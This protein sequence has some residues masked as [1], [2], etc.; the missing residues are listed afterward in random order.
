[1][2]VLRVFRKRQ[3][4]FFWKKC[5]FFGKKGCKIASAA[6]E[7]PIASGGWGSAPK[8][9]RYYSRPLFAPFCFFSV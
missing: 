2:R 3:D 4:A 6:Q 9:L 5:V 1:V 8:L 7:P